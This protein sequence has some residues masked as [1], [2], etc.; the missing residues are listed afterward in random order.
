[1]AFS[2]DV[3]FSL[4]LRP[5]G[6]AVLDTKDKHI[7]VWKAVSSVS[8]RVRA[9]KHNTLL[10]RNTPTDTSVPVLSAIYLPSFLF[11]GAKCETEKFLFDR[12]IGM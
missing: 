6:R 2:G 8:Q 11:T 5:G 10:G 4:R 9:C 12:N 3:V 7:C 1:M